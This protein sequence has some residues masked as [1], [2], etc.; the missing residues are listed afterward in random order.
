M[1]SA[2]QSHPCGQSQAYET[3]FCDVERKYES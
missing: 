3:H 1:L 2:T